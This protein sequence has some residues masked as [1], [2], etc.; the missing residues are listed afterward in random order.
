MIDHHQHQ[1]LV[2]LSQLVL[3]VGKGPVEDLPAR[4]GSGPWPSARSLPTPGTDEDL[5][6]LDI[7]L[8]C[9][10]SLHGCRASRW[11]TGPRTHACERPLPFCGGS[12]PISAVTSARPPPVTLAPRI[13]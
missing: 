3:V 1:A 9:H 2:D 11:T 13:I 12:F 4:P 10:L 5:A 7:H 8:S 6:V